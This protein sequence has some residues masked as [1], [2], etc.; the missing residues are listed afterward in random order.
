M[1]RRENQRSSMLVHGEVIEDESYV[2]G[3]VDWDGDDCDFRMVFH[4]IFNS[5][6]LICYPCID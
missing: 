5:D 4:S 3:F 6:W 2:I 1:N